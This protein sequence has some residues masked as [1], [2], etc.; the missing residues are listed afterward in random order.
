MTAVKPRICSSC[1]ADEMAC[2]M[3]AGLGGRRCCDHCDHE[4]VTS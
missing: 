2:Q 3:K 1:G 4:D